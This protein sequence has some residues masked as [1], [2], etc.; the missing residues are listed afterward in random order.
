MFFDV[1]RT[2]AEGAYREYELSVRI[3]ALADGGIEFRNDNKIVWGLIFKKMSL[4]TTVARF[5][6][7]VLRDYPRGEQ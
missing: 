2:S 6:N 5:K 1:G 3:K 4:T 7:V